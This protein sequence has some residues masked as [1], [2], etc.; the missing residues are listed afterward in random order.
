MTTF[1]Q[2]QLFA[3]PTDFGSEAAAFLDYHHKNPQVWVAIVNTAAEMFEAGLLKASMTTVVEL[4]RWRLT[5]DALNG[6]VKDEVPLS[7]ADG[8]GTRMVDINNNY[9][10]WY[11]RLVVWTGNVPEGFFS[12]RRSVA[13]ENLDAWASAAGVW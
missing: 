2:T 1:S 3:D 12:L 8:E 7:A 9:T 6:V 10:A 4:V 5:R 11:A 13:D